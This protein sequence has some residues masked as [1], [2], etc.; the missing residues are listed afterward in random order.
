MDVE[1][2]AAR[3]SILDLYAQYTHAVDSHDGD[4]F[5]DCFTE[6]GYTDISSFPTVDHLREASLPWLNSDGTIRGSQQLSLA[7]SG[8]G[9]QTVS[10]HH[11]TMNTWVKSIDGDKAE[12][13]AYFVVFAND[14]GAV[15]HYGVYE[16]SLARC[17]DGKW[18][19]DRRIDRCLYERS[20][21]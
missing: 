17:D 10:L 16:D 3:L 4:L 9:P 7:V 11:C 8:G 12:G 5:A 15:E 6:N 18:R 14:D 20:R 2:M 13:A 19:I 1:E 21:G